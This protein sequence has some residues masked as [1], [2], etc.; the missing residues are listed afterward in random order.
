VSVSAIPGRVVLAHRERLG[1]HRPQESLGVLDV[2]LAIEVAPVVPAVGA[3]EIGV[4][5]SG[6]REVEALAVEGMEFTCQKFVVPG[7]KVRKPVVGNAADANLRR[8]Q[9]GPGGSPARYRGRACG[10]PAT[11]RARQ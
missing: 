10:P 7:A 5:E 6:Q 8:G 11:A 2:D 9:Y 3:V 4:I 1:E